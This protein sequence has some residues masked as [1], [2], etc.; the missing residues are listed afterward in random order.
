MY[1]GT[2]ASHSGIRGFPT[3][4]CR[5]AGWSWKAVGA[6]S[7]AAAAAAVEGA[8]AAGVAETAAA[9]ETRKIYA[10]L[11]ASRYVTAVYQVI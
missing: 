8:A 10:T 5:L 2:E 9:V 11:E 3:A 4:R 7:T 6:G 1:S